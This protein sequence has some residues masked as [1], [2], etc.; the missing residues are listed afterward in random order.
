MAHVDPV[1][2]HGTYTITVT[3][4]NGRASLESTGR[5]DDGRHDNLV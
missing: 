2:F 3:V 5:C 1:N 4:P